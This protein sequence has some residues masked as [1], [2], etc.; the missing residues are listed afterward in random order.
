MNK[1]RAVALIASVAIAAVVL[2]TAAIGFAATTTVPNAPASATCPAAGA[3]LRMGPV[4]RD[5]GGRLIDIVAKLTGKSIDAIVADRQAGK[6]L[7]QIAEEDGVSTSA[8]VDEALKV[9]EQLLAEQ[10]AS[11]R[12]TQEQADAVLEQMQTRLTEQ[13]E[14]QNTACTG[15]GAGSGAG[16]GA[17]AGAGG[18]RGAGRGMGYGAC[19]N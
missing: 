2:G 1:K 15:A 10:V 6:T 11:G 14:T 3:G 9:R 12:I 18:G 8:V 16:R 5:S 17:G 4:I 13:L 7:A 19:Q